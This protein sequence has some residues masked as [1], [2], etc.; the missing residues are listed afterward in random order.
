MPSSRKMLGDGRRHLRGAQPLDAAARRWSRPRPPTRSPALGCP[1]SCSRNSPTSRPRS[2][3]SA[4]T[5]TSALAPRA[6][7][8]SSV[9]LPTPEPANSPTRWPD[10][11]R[12]QTVDGAHA[13]GERLVDRR[14][15]SAGG[16]ARSTG[17]GSG[18]EAAAC[19]RAAGRD[20]RAR[21]RAARR[22]RRPAKARP[23]TRPRSSGPTPAS[24]PSG[25]AR[26]SPPSKPTISAGNGSPRRL[27]R[28]TSPIR[29]PG[30]ES[31]MLR[32]VTAET[33][34]VA[35]SAGVSA[36]RARKRSLSTREA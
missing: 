8:P 4:T 28:T 19:R 36:S 24:S 17:T 21:D 30:I 26:A 22:R 14:R 16:G 10:A 12:E 5:T 31:R 15:P 1:A 20:R 29:T 11:E 23:S 32:P 13:G 33:R 6:I 7:A 25:S 35:P 9:L 2:P 27:T 3:T 18:R 34:P